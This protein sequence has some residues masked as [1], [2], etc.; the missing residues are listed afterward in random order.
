MPNSIVTKKFVRDE[1]FKQSTLFTKAINQILERF[2]KPEEKMDKRFEQ[3][4][5]KTELLDYKVELMDELKVIREEQ[6]ANY[7][8]DVRQNRRL[9]VIETHLNLAAA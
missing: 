6:Q 7:S 9:D 2:D 5:T 8:I 3:V 1:I 4:P